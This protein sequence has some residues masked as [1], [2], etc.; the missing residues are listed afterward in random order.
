MVGSTLGWVRGKCR[1]RPTSPFM[2]PA[3][4]AEELTRDEYEAEL[5]AM[6]V[7]ELRSLVI[8]LDYEAATVAD[9]DVDELVDAAMG[10]KFP[11]EPSEDGVP[12]TG[13]LDDDVSDDADATPAQGVTR[14][15]LAEMKLPTLRQL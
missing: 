2:N 4:E 12:A 15:E 13:D 8:S 3:P 9:A 7:E 14:E 1:R 6:D 10:E 11:E 5:R